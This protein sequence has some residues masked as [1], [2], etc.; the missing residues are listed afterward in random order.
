[1]RYG[2]SHGQSDDSIEHNGTDYPTRSEWWEICAVD[3]FGQR[4]ELIAVTPAGSKCR[5]FMDAIISFL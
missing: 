4:V 3:R 5:V 1:M 2:A